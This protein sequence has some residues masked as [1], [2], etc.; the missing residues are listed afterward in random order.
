MFVPIHPRAVA[1]P[2]L[3]ALL[4]R[5]RREERKARAVGLGTLFDRHLDPYFRLDNPHF[6]ITIWRVAAQATD[7]SCL[8]LPFVLV[9]YFVNT[10]KHPPSGHPPPTAGPVP[11]PS[12][13]M[14]PRLW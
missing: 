13:R 3:E 11:Q 4:R 5:E 10:R 1:A 12:L 9:V 7:Q 2:A 6:G 14:L 8:L